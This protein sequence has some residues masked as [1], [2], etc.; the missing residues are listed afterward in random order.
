MTPLSR[1]RRIQRLLP[2][3]LRS[4][5]FTDGARHAAKLRPSPYALGQSARR[6]KL[7]HHGLLIEL[8]WLTDFAAYH[9][10]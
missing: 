2:I 8:R 10:K 7:I 5:P 4:D 6:Y 1:I 9:C 3:L